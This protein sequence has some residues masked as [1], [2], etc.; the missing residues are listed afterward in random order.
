MEKIASNPVCGCHGLFGPDSR[1]L[2]ILEILDTL[3]T[4]FRDSRD[5]SSEKTPFVMIPLLF[6]P[7]IISAINFIIITPEFILGNSWLLVSLQYMKVKITDILFTDERW[8]WEL[9]K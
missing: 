4:E 8:F 7:R 9:F 1:E 6:R 2:E 5:S 3:Q